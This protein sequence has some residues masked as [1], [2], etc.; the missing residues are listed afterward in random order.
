MTTRIADDAEG[1]AV[2]WCTMLAG[3]FFIEALHDGGF[4]TYDPRIPYLTYLD[5]R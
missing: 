5:P 4:L 1:F 2:T 3:C